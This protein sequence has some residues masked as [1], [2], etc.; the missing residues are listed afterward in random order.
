MDPL[1]ANVVRQLETILGRPLRVSAENLDLL[2]KDDPEA[3]RVL[4]DI[5]KMTC[6][7]WPSTT[8]EGQQ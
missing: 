1:Q 6:R 8:E 4:G 3:F 5:A 2:P 7:I